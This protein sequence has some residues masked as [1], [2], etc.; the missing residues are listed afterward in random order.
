MDTVGINSIVLWKMALSVRKEAMDKATQ[1]YNSYVT[2][3]K[4]KIMKDPFAKAY[5]S[6][7]L[8]SSTGTN[9][10]LINKNH[11]QDDIA[12]D[13]LFAMVQDCFNFRVNNA[14]DLKD[15]DLEKSGRDFW[16]IRNRQEAAFW[17]RNLGEVGDRLI[18]AA[19]KFGDVH[20]HV[21]TDR[22]V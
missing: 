13:T 15:L 19:A 6:C 4:N 21:N 8:C 16:R 11:S 17:N 9:D 2:E 20:L 22:H 18:K 14:A 3:I 10:D 5:I 12:L 7:A 1:E